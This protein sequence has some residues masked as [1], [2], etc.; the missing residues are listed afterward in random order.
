MNSRPRHARRNETRHTARLLLRAGLMATAAGAVV[1]A[2]GG[3]AAA[4]PAAA[5]NQLDTPV[6]T[7]NSTA[8]DK[9][10]GL[11]VHTVTGGLTG[12][13]GKATGPVKS[14][15]GN[16]MAGSRFNPA[17]NAVGTQISDLEPVDTAMATGPLA[18]GQ[19]VGEL[20]VA[21]QAS[22]LLPG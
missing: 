2:T 12:G 14:L 3:S 18:K 22:N 8:L 20:P 1:G 11:P 17:D 16:P 9:P 19:P 21:G 7:A 10:G 15:R 4:A 6:T 5:P 13:A